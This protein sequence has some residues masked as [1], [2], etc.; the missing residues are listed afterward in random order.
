MYECLNSDIVLS[1]RTALESLDFGRREYT[2]TETGQLYSEDS[3]VL[4]EK[5][6]KILYE[7]DSFLSLE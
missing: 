6:Q 4:R 7:Y 2:F 3:S 1:R 5:G